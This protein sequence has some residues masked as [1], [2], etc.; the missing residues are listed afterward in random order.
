MPSSSP[1][2]SF[3]VGSIYGLLFDIQVCFCCLTWFSSKVWYNLCITK[4]PHVYVP[5]VLVWK[6]ECL[7]FYFCKQFWSPFFSNSTEFSFLESFKPWMPPACCERACAAVSPISV[8]P[9][10]WELSS[11]VWISDFT[12]RASVWRKHGNL[13][14]QKKQLGKLLRM[15]L[16][17]C[18][19]WS[20]HFDKYSF[21]RGKSGLFLW[22]SML[23]F[24]WRK[25]LFDSSS[26]STLPVLYTAVISLS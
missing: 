21:C 22:I 2:I 23:C 26:L 25:L 19:L 4:F 7:S 10:T 20:F 1:V 6:G 16:L 9:I 12:W 8:Q 5:L 13:R 24:Q 14:W 18:F 17:K 3:L 15:F 11:H